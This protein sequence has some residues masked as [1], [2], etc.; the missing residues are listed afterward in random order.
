M[1]NAKK[2]AIYVSMTALILIWLMPILYLV[3]SALKS[4]NEF[5]MNGMFSLPQEPTLKNFGIAWKKIKPYF[6]NSLFYVTV[7]V[8]I[9]VLLS[10]MAAYA[11]SRFEF[12]GKHFLVGLLMLGML[13]PAH[14]TLLPNYLVLKSFHLLNKPAGLILLYVSL[15]ISFTFFL[16][17]GHFLGI[18]REIEE[19][20]M[21]DG[22]PTWQIFFRIILPMSVPVL[23]IALVMNYLNV[24]NDLV[25]SI[26]YVTKDEMLPVTAGLLR[27]TEEY[28]QHYERMTAGIL[29]SIIPL[30]VIF[31]AAQKYIVA[32]M[33]EGALKG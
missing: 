22:C 24:W 4:P 12:K 13:L 23:I 5:F 11:L 10:S 33:A 1:K 17:R 19:A 32:G 2:I 20:A 3:N 25:L 14:V 27:F 9:I 29:I 16:T 30:S 31:I 18:N 8:P 26:V 7:S 6:L 28:A 21:V 15:N